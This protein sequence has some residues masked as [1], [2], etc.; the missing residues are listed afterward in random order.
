MRK[1]YCMGIRDFSKTYCRCVAD[2]DVLVC[3]LL[4]CCFNSDIIIYSLY[5]SPRTELIFTPPTPPH[6]VRIYDEEFTC[7]MS[8]AGLCRPAM[9]VLRSHSDNSH[10][11][12]WLLPAISSIVV[13]HHVIVI[14]FLCFR[15]FNSIRV[16]SSAI[17]HSH[18]H[19][20][21]DI[22]QQR[23]IVVDETGLKWGVL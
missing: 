3:K 21:K 23:S 1:N 12:I 22:S 5:T 16:T 15:F 8:C 7:Y 17:N 9:S 6:R 2:V 19:Y 18:C 10:S 4:Y 20:C 13:I 11:L 14:Y